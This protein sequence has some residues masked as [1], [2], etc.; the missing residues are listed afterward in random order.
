MRTCLE[1]SVGKMEN[2]YEVHTKVQWLT[3]GKTLGWSNY[4]RTSLFCFVLVSFNGTLFLL[5]RGTERQ[6]MVIQPW[7]FGRHV[8]QTEWSE[9]APSKKAIDDICC[10]W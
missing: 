8:P 7:V 9:P 10:Q 1:H 5:E 4:N 2:F 3:Q 6:N